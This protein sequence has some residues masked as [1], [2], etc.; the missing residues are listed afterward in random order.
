MYTYVAI[1][2]ITNLIQTQKQWND[3]T[4]KTHQTKTP[5]K[6]K[7]T[8]KHVVFVRFSCLFKKVSVTH[9]FFAFF[10]LSSPIHDTSLPG[11]F[12]GPFHGCCFLLDC[13]WLLFWGLF[14]TGCRYCVY[15]YMQIYLHT[16]N[17]AYFCEHVL[18]CICIPIF[19]DVDIHIYMYI[20]YI[21]IHIHIH[22]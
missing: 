16:Y 4:L 12:L 2:W 3:K 1:S 19:M 7:S 20:T 21:Y 5:H 8:I 13:F 17:Y 15:F 18:T 10:Q 9:C 11:F 22:I 6:N 14:L